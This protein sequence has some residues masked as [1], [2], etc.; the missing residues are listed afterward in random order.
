[1]ASSA[2]PS[3]DRSDEPERVW[4]IFAMSAAA[5]ANSAA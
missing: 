2:Q 3:I 5:A 1:M 4:S